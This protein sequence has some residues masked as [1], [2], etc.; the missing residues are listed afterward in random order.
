M[1]RHDRRPSRC[2][3]CAQ[4]AQCLQRCPGV[5]GGMASLGGQ[6]T[7]VPCAAWRCGVVGKWWVVVG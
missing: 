1:H 2:Q 5:F 6:A 4:C 3:A 7:P